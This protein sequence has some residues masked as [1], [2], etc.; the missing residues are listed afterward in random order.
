MKSVKKLLTKLIFKLS[1]R[2][3][4]KVIRS[5]LKLQYDL[6]NDLCVKLA[7]TEQELQAA[8]EL[9]HDSYVQQGY[10]QPQLYKLR[11][12]FF[13]LL[14]STSLIIAKK[15]DDVIGT[16]SI[17]R[18]SPHGLPLEKDFNLNHLRKNNQVISEISSLAIHRDY[19]GQHGLVLFP[20]LKFM[21]NYCKYYF[22]TDIMVLATHPKLSDFFEAILLFK[23]IEDKVVENYGFVNGSPAVG[24]YLD[25]KLAPMMY[26]AVYGL[27]SNNKNLYKFMVPEEHGGTDFQNLK[28]PLRVDYRLFDTKITGK[29]FEEIFVNKV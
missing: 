15:G 28:Y 3:R 16:V 18:D 19:R 17:I 7:D 10:M 21:Y 9:L 11:A 6:P 22:A 20:L 23:S 12:T 8:F 2:L 1:P 5:L 14:P 27:K 24:K 13:H 25:L 29:T 4:Y 26:A